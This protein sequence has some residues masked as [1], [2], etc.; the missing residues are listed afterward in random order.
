MKSSVCRRSNSSTYIHN[1]HGTRLYILHGEREASKIPGLSCLQYAFITIYEP[2][3]HTFLGFLSKLAYIFAVAWQDRVEEHPCAAGRRT[4][5]IRQASRTLTELQ[6]INLQKHF[7]LCSKSLRSTTLE[8]QTNRRG[9]SFP[10]DDTPYSSMQ[11]QQ[12][13]SRR[14]MTLSG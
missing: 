3:T 12:V 4:L 6:R 10:R 11:Y 9:T 7:K 2:P 14:T 1:N 13:R 5:H 8:I